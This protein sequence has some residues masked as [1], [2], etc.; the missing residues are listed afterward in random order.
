MIGRNVLILPGVVHSAL[1]KRVRSA[2]IK[3]AGDRYA[4]RT[5]GIVLLK[6]EITPDVGHSRFIQEP[7]AD[8]PGIADGVILSQDFLCRSP[9]CAE[10]R[11]YRSGWVDLAYQSGIDKRK[12][13]RFETLWST[14][15]VFEK[16]LYG[17]GSGMRIVP[18]WTG[19]PLIA[20]LRALS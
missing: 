19:T 15:T 2:K 7:G 11:Y 4:G 18:S 8:D 5:D 3:G 14:R 12:C 10:L 6:L 20:P 17:F 1:R 9:P 13:P 16:K